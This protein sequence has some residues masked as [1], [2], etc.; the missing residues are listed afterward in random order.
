MSMNATCGV[1][2]GVR[3]RVRVAACTQKDALLLCKLTCVLQL[4]L[5]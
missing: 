2:V 1:R 4:L 3:V 5:L